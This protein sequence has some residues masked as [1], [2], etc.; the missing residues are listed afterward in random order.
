MINK[1]TE[2]LRQISG[3]ERSTGFK[4]AAILIG[5]AIPM[6][7]VPIVLILISNYIDG[8]WPWLLAFVVKAV[9]GCLSAFFMLWTVITQWKLGHGTPAPI[10][11]TQKLII[12]GPYKLCRNPI[13]LGLCFL[14][15]AAG[16]HFGDLSTGIFCFIVAM[17]LGSLYHKFVEE[18]ELVLRFGREYEEYRKQTPFIIP[19]I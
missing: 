10:A 2:K 1:F 18:K 5:G 17:I 14:Y 6:V 7:V 16:T 8:R 4:L 11:P 19:K 12:A 15:M 9:T 13:Q 3:R